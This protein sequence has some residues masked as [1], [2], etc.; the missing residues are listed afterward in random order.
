MFLSTSPKT[1]RRVTPIAV[2]LI[3][4]RL[5]LVLGSMLI[6]TLIVWFVVNFMYPEQWT[7]FGE[8]TNSKGEIERAKTLW[9]WLELLVVPLM[10]LLFGIGINW[11][12]Q[13]NERTRT[14][15]QTKIER[16]RNEA[17]SQDERIRTEAQAQ[18]EREI[19]NDRLRDQTLHNYFD[20]MSELLLQEKLR[21]A[22]PD[23]EVR[24]VARAWTL[25]SLG[26]LDS[27]RKGTLL[28]FLWETGLIRHGN[29]MVRLVNAD[30]SG[31]NLEKAYLE[32]ADLQLVNLEKSNLSYGAFYDAFLESAKL[33]GANLEGAAFLRANLVNAEFKGAICS[34]NFTDAN[35]ESA[36]FE[37]AN[38]E[39]AHLKRANLAGAIFRKSNLAWAHLENANLEG[40]N[41]TDANLEG[42]HLEGANLNR[43]W[44]LTPKQLAMATLDAETILQDGSKYKPQK[45]STPVHNEV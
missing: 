39:S 28:N 41:F 8:F 2:K 43:A 26:S 5:P 13:N 9:D 18:I 42:T 23:N 27:T 34:A 21:Q 45:V 11:T 1:L 10:L 38:L 14:E 20:R 32:K 17:R 19:A 16:A 35:L 22:G 12:I 37:G 25:T 36:D 4:K 29:T 15:A 30:F 6:I 40:V 3:H 7:G 31:A 44:G 33:N 24:I